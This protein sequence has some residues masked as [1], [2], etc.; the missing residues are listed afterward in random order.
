VVDKFLACGILKHGFARV[1]CDACRH[2]FLLA[3]S[4]RSYCTSFVLGD[5]GA[6]VQL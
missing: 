5:I 4:C 3:L 2:E 6:H 1:R